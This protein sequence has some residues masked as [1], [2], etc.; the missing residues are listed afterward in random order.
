MAHED[1]QTTPEKIRHERHGMTTYTKEWV[2]TLSFFILYVLVA[3]LG[4]WVMMIGKNNDL[5]VLGYPLHFFLVIILG[6]LGVLAISLVWNVMANRLAD[7]I[8][9]H[10]PGQTNDQ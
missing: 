4:P 9:N 2:F 1:K 6:W 5:R 8:A 7:E 10:S 3:H